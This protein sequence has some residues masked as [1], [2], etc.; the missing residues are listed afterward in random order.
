MTLSGHVSVCVCTCVPVHVCMLIHIHVYAAVLQ[1]TNV[2][3]EM[4]SE[5]KEILKMFPVK[6]HSIIKI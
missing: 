6:E 2:K 4:K 5:R 3:L 1:Y